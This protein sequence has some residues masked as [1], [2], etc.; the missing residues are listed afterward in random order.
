MHAR[1]TMTARKLRSSTTTYYNLRYLEREDPRVERQPHPGRLVLHQRRGG[2]RLGG[3]S[4]GSSPGLPAPHRH[5]RQRDL[6]QPRLL[7]QLLA[8]E[9]GPPHRV[10]ARELAPPAAGGG[11]AEDVGRG[12]QE[13]EDALD[14]GEAGEGAAVVAAVVAATA[15]ISTVRRLAA[16]ARAVV[17]R[18]LLHLASFE[19]HS[20]HA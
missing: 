11:G 20:P 1:V 6:E 10:G 15:A 18:A 14:G 13:V 3:G 9:P 4:G 19:I 2:G 17:L 12:R 7:H 5:R 16:L 8:P